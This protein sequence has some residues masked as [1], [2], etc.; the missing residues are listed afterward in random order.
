[1]ATKRVIRFTISY[2]DGA[3]PHTYYR[4]QNNTGSA[5]DDI[6]D[7]DLAIAFD[8]D[9][10]IP[11]NQRH[12]L[13]FLATPWMKHIIGKMGPPIVHSLGKASCVVF[14]CSR[15]R[16][17]PPHAAAHFGSKAIAFVRNDGTVLRYTLDD[18]K[19]QC[20]SPLV[21]MHCKGCEKINPPAHR[22]YMASEKAEQ[23]V[24]G[25]AAEKFKAWADKQEGLVLATEEGQF[26]TLYLEE[27][28]QLLEGIRLDGFA[29]LRPHLAQ[30]RGPNPRAGSI[31]PVDQY[32]W[33]SADEIETNKELYTAAVQKGR[34]SKE[35]A[36][37]CKQCFL[38]DSCR[39]RY[40]GLGSFA[41]YCHHDQ[42]NGSIAGTPAGPFSEELWK[43]GLKRWE[44][45]H[46]YVDWK[47]VSLFAHGVPANFSTKL[48][49]RTNGLSTRLVRMTQDLDGV[50]FSRGDTQI[51]VSI[52]AAKTILRAEGASGFRDDYELSPLE[53]ALYIEACTLQKW[54]TTSRCPYNAGTHSYA[55]RS[56]RIHG[57]NRGQIDFTWFSRGRHINDATGYEEWANHRFHFWGQGF[58]KPT[59]LMSLVPQTVLDEHRLK[60]LEL[61]KQAMVEKESYKRKPAKRDKRQYKLNLVLP[62]TKES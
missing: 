12:L 44:E 25:C 8:E 39:H 38:Y 30:D 33:P 48:A 31:Q 24:Q 35:R 3:I 14:P 36:V 11:A 20:D 9:L 54:C 32:D 40:R 23:A 18:F 26:T 46:P 37:I 52:E 1:M 45:A 59:Y 60:L 43:L 5:R 28:R 10:A 22:N 16:P 51:R 56:V 55:L 57:Y 2:V 27:F 13:R 62:S 42:G 29:Y 4:R 17:S 50:V 53:R 6:R 15:G 21:L 58:K 19:S 49:P 47:A 34:E 61:H 7:R 41:E